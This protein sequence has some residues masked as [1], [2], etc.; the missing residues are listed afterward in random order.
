[1]EKIKYKQLTAFITICMV[2]ALLVFTSEILLHKL[3]LIGT[4]VVSIASF[5]APVWFVLSDIIAET[6][7]YKISK[8]MFYIFLVTIFIFFISIDLLIHIPSPSTWHQQVSY[9]YVLGGLTRQFIAGAVAF[10]IGG[11]M[12][13]KLLL[14]WKVIL[15][16]KYFWIRSFLS[17]LVGELIFTTIAY[18]IIIYGTH[19]GLS[20]NIISL[21]ISGFL[22]K[23]IGNIVLCPI[24]II[25][26]NYLKGMGPI[27][28]IEH[29]EPYNPFKLDDQQ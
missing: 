14:K 8:I 19:D 4:H 24:S 26:L 3:V 17:S 7:G 23:S 28:F 12:N 22:L 13:I 16:G 18:T 6:Y 21:I 29:S 20:N 5:I 11:T 1:M 2:Y 10:I 27:Y 15:D 9:N 25:L